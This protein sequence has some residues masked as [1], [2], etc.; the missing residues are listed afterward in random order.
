MSKK[1]KKDTLPDTVEEC[2]TDFPGFEEFDD[3]FYFYDN[4][5]WMD[6][7][8]DS[9]ME[10]GMEGVLG[11]TRT[12]DTKFYQQI[13]QFLSFTVRHNLSYEAMKDLIE[14]MGLDEKELKSV[15]HLRKWLR[16]FTVQPVT[17]FLCPSPVCTEFFKETMLPS[18]CP[19]CAVALNRRAL[20]RD[21]RYFLYIPLGQ[22]MRSF[23]EVKENEELVYQF[24]SKEPESTDN[25]TDVTDSVRYKTL[26]SVGKI[27]S[28][29]VGQHPCYDS[30]TFQLNLDGVETAQS[31]SN[32]LYPLQVLF[33]EI[34]PSLRRKYILTPFLFLK[35]KEKDIVFNQNYLSV[36]VE[37]CKE[38]Y[39]SGLN[40]TSSLLGQQCCSRIIPY[41]L[42]CDSVM[43]PDL[44]GIKGHAGYS[45]CPA[46]TIRGDRLPKG[47]GFTMCK[48]PEL[49]YDN[50]PIYSTLRSN[51]NLEVN[52]D[53]QRFVP[54]LKNLPQF[55]VFECCS[56]DAMH[57]VYLGLFK[58]MFSLLFVESKYDCSMTPKGRSVAA[59]VMKGICGTSWITRGPR[60][61]ASASFW[62]ASE[63]RNFGFF[64]SVVIL[65]V[66]V[67]RKFM[68]KEI[69]E[70]WLHLINGLSLLNS[71]RI[72]PEDFKVAKISLEQFSVFY[73][74][75][76]GSNNCSINYHLIS[77]M[78]DYVKYLGPLWATSLFNNE[79]YNSTLL[80][81]FRVGS[82][83]LL[84]QCAERLQMSSFTLQVYSHMLSRMDKSY[85]CALAEK[86]WRLQLFPESI[87]HGK[88]ST[89]EVFN[90]THVFDS[91]TFID[92]ALFKN[93]FRN[94]TLQFFDRI[95]VKGVPFTTCNYRFSCE[96][97]R[98]VDCF[99]YSREGNVFG[100][101]DKF[102]CTT[103]GTY[104]AIFRILDVIGTVDNVN[105]NT[106]LPPIF[107]EL[108]YLKRYSLTAK[109]S[110][111]ELRRISRKCLSM[112]F[113]DNVG[114]IGYEQ[115]SYEAA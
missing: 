90:D 78:V 57:C 66:L 43:K 47:N 8:P 26:K 35:N 115:N 106:S 68:K 19:S 114:F 36:F 76:Y 18:N 39:V 97:R 12:K 31:A 103:E 69:F 96:N 73:P 46:C 108:A 110:F 75:L 55:D 60:S 22:L 37:E 4:D 70:N 10:G 15:Y 44:I 9:G 1:R 23:L 113:L 100:R 79:G 85:S 62:K 45:S 67:S 7:E 59:Q 84:K 71:T 111:L 107:Y 3:F 27:E 61:L 6:T 98:K 64:Y 42:N 11:E 17:Y 74:T 91:F 99:F 40:W 81:S 28:A 14:L 109:Y 41:S 49:D 65:D 102:I 32:S 20:S 16:D 95:V 52:K 93:T 51:E 24:I 82:K 94:A 54:L 72:S 87:R 77:H 89:I 83:G 92:T 86:I 2:V 33:N 48:V 5:I 21:G 56:I 105:D 88:A 34:F 80:N 104:Y 50:N 13:L 30:F 53:G 29:S 112:G 58:Q 63:W 25:M 101:I 38:L